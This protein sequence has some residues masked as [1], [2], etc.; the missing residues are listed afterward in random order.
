MGWIRIRM[1]PE[2]GK[3][4]AGSG[5]AT[6][7]RSTSSIGVIVLC[8]FLVYMA[9]TVF[10]L[11]FLLKQNVHEKMHFLVDLVSGTFSKLVAYCLLS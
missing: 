9:L 6:L 1:V 2:L 4:K 11:S 3:F 7:Q 5:S 8:I 10:I